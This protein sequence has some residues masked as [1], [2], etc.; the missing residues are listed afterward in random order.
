[1]IRYLQNYVLETF[2]ESPNMRTR[3][4]IQEEEIKQQK[5]DKH[6]IAQ[7]WKNPKK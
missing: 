4:S 5:L 7:L 1:M 2:M 3:E 6:I